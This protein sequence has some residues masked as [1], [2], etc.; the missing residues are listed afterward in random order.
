MLHRYKV[1]VCMWHLKAN[2]GDT[3]PF[4]RD[5]LTDCRR[6]SPCEVPEL[7]I[8][9]C[10]Q[11]ENIIDLPLRYH[12]Y[13]STNQRHDVQK[14]E[15]MLVLGHLVARD[16]TPYDFAEDRGHEWLD[17]DEREISR[18]S[19]FMI[20]PGVVISATSPTFLPSSPLPMGDVTEIFAAF[21]SASFSATSV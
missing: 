1:N 19:S 2:H 15:A 5:C 3:Y 21:K 16:F 13:M 7:T 18:T 17:Q 11:V 9:F 10:I 14:G 4:T 6:H 12:Q 8:G 20:P